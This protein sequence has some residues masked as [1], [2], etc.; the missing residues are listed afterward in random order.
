[1]HNGPFDVFTPM[2]KF[3][4]LDLESYVVFKNCAKSQM[5]V[6]MNSE[7]T[8]MVSERHQMPL[9]VHFQSRF[10]LHLLGELGPGDGDPD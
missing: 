2:W 9:H 8:T 6:K 10:M 3:L 5:R 1:M 7:C 4:Q